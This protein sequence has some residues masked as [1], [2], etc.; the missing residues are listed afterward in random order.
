MKP[1]A[2]LFFHLFDRTDSAPQVSEFSKFVL[3]GLKAFM[4][5]PMSD[6]SLCLFSAF[7]PVLVIHLFE[8]GDLPAE[9][10]NLFPKHC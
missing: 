6:L 10:P 7:A 2:M 5:L 4:P 1:G 3:D 9:T 8:F